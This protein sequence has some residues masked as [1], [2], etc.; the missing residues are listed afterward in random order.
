MK[1]I[2]NTALFKQNKFHFT[3]ESTSLLNSPLAHILERVV[4]YIVNVYGQVWLEVY[5]FRNTFLGINKPIPFKKFSIRHVEYFLTYFVLHTQISTMKS[6]RIWIRPS[7]H[8]FVKNILFNHLTGQ[9]PAVSHQRF[10]SPTSGDTTDRDTLHGGREGG[11]S[12][13]TVGS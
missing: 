12:F 13:F 1:G 7:H 4:N 9:T 8:K 3:S 11:R 10:I 5:L 2:R 6:M